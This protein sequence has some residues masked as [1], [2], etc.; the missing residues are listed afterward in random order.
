MTIIG[1][2]VQEK[3]QRTHRGVTININIIIIGIVNVI[4]VLFVSFSFSSASTSST[5]PFFTLAS[6]SP[7]MCVHN[8]RCFNFILIPFTH[9]M[10]EGTCIE[11]PV[12]LYYFVCVFGDIHSLCVCVHRTFNPAIQS[13]YQ[14]YC[15]IQFETGHKIGE[16]RFSAKR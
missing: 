10:P 12:P 6:R 5:S 15:S 3:E 16:R 4:I 9:T 2:V 7:N 8:K 14:P 13:I 1:R 11:A